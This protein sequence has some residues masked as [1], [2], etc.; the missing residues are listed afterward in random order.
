MQKLFNVQIA[1]LA[2]KKRKVIVINHWCTITWFTISPT[3]INHYTIHD[4]C[5]LSRWA[6]ISDPSCKPVSQ[7]APLMDPTT[8]CTSLQWD[9]LRQ[10]HGWCSLRPNGRSVTDS[11][12]LP[13]H[14]AGFAY[15][16]VA[17]RSHLI[18]TP[19][20][21]RCSRPKPWLVFEVMPPIK[22]N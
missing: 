7:A 21:M 3:S 9:P 13:L 8:R 19:K 17:H 6:M 14:F 2:F 15:E 1:S 16:T 18:G 20:S 11:T 5:M 10:A 12:G 22:I 4:F